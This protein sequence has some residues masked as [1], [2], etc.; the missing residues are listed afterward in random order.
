MHQTQKV[1]WI[2]GWIYIFQYYQASCF[3]RLTFLMI[4]DTMDMFEQYSTIDQY[5]HNDTLITIHFDYIS[6]HF[7]CTNNTFIIN[8]HIF[9]N[10]INSIVGFIFCQKKGFMVS[11]WTFSDQSRFNILIKGESRLT[12]NYPDIS[13]LHQLVRL[14]NS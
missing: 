10:Y 2:N 6:C 8:W 5:N 7:F 12:L 1:H 11:L 3:H 14:G 4:V 13:N 9:W